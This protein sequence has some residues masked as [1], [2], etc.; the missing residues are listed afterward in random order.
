MRRAAGIAFGVG[1]HLLFALTVWQLFWFLKGSEAPSA[2]SGR[3]LPLGAVA[4]DAALAMFFAVPHSAMLL[5]TVRRKLAR[6]V[7][8]A[9]YGCLYCTVTC[10]CLLVIFTAWQSSPAILWH[11]TGFAR[12]AIQAA[13]LGSWAALFYSLHLT[14]LGYQ[15]GWTPWWHWLVGKPLPPRKFVPWGAYL[16]LRH[17]VYLSFLGLIWFVPTMTADRAA[18]T[19]VWT[20]YIFAGSYL[21]DRR[22]IYYLGGKYRQYQ[23]AVPGYPGMLFGPLSRVPLPVEEPGIEG[24]PFELPLQRKVMRPTAV[25][26]AA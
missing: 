13:F 7:P 11:F 1:N 14:G 25:Q 21:K 22:L 2:A 3:S 20:M 5:P 18:L 8:D 26:K 10:T 12:T 17:P 9:F 16:W 4:A 23:A 15:T 6:V 24:R 19:A